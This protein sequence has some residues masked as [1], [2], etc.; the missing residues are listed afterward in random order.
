MEGRVI[1]SGIFTFGRLR[2]RITGRPIKEWCPQ[3]KQWMLSVTK[4]SCSNCSNVTVREPQREHRGCLSDCADDAADLATDFFL[5]RPRLAGVWGIFFM[6]CQSFAIGDSP[7]F[8]NSL[9]SLV[10]ARRRKNMHK[11]L[12]KKKKRTVIFGKVG[13]F[14]HEDSV[15]KSMGRVEIVPMVTEGRWWRA[16]RGW[17]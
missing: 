1:E 10:P 13:N 12:Q 16:W 8:D 5:G 14:F 17:L 7:L 2:S 9:T 6:G 3:I 15:E 4:S 11:S